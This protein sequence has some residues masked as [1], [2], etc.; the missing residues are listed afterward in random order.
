MAR[1]LTFVEHHLVLVPSSSVGRTSRMKDEQH[2]QLNKQRHDNVQCVISTEDTTRGDVVKLLASVQH[3]SSENQI[4]VYT[5]TELS[6]AKGQHVSRIDLEQDVRVRLSE[7]FRNV[8]L[9]QDV[10]GMDCSKS[11]QL[12]A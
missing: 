5:S 7:Y 10:V 8:V 2:V 6:H 4:T 11:P 1:L 9:C 3:T 12:P